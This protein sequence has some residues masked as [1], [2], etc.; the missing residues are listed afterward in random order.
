M[1]AT[2]QMNNKKL[3][4][5]LANNARASRPKSK[6]ALAPQ[7]ERAVKSLIRKENNKEA[8][9]HHYRAV[10]NSSVST[11]PL[12]HTGM[13]EIPAGGT[14]T[15]LERL[16]DE[17]KLQSLDIRGYVQY[18]DSTNIIRLLILQWFGDQ[19]PTAT[20]IFDDT[21]SGSTQ[22]FGPVRKDSRGIMKV[23][24]DDT[25]YVAGA[26]VGYNFK[27]FKYYINKGFKR[28]IHYYGA[29]STNA[30]NKIFLVAVSD[31]G[32]AGHPPIYAYSNATFKP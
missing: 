17:L 2:V 19:D 12:I 1:S 24:R 27:F 23:L 6:K 8:Q 18:A 20:E 5:A 32:G 3:R 14:G 26:N 7:Q 10:L 30:Y 21:T 28:N 16:G 15:D 9:Y 31:S 4:Q 22:I 13:T 11:T 29:S 25:F